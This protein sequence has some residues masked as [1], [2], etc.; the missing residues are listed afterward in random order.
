MHFI[1]SNHHYVL[2]GAIAFAVRLGV[3]RERSG[4]FGKEDEFNAFGV[5]EKG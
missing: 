5:H 2:G 1:Q 3:R 4:G